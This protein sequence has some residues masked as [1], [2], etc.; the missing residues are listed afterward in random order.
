L[1]SKGG[2]DRRQ[3]KLLYE[4]LHPILFGLSNHG[5]LGGHVSNGGGG[6]NAYRVFV[7]KRKGKKLAEETRQDNNFKIN[8]LKI[9]C[10]VAY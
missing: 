4:E 9:I 3:R 8:L 1:A 7:G 2:S 5:V 10:E 6:G